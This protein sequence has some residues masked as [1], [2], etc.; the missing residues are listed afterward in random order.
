[1][2][3]LQDPKSNLNSLIIIASY[4]EPLIR[5]MLSNS[6]KFKNSELYDYKKNQENTYNMENINKNHFFENL[7]KF[8]I[9][10]RIKLGDIKI[11]NDVKKF[12]LSKTFN[13][14]PLLLHELLDKLLD[15]NLIGLDKSNSNLVCSQDLLNMIEFKDYSKL[16]LPYRIEKLMGNIIDTIKNQNE[17]IILKAA[18]VIG[19]IFDINTLY[20]INPIK[21]IMNE[22]LLKMIYYFEKINVLEILND[23][24]PEKLVAKFSLPFFREVLYSRM[25]SEQKTAIHSEIARNFKNMKYSYMSS[26]KELDIL[27]RHLLESENTVMNIMDKRKEESKEK[28]NRQISK[29]NDG[30]K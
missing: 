26:E 13:G 11:K 22:D 19:N 8:Y 20:Q 30:G 7:I 9:S 29:P 4:Q 24:Q 16:E 5:Y 21:N 1:M 18:S 12:L 17:I 25:L 15:K 23:I 10:K 2:K 6:D 3:K 28:E 27:L 14:N